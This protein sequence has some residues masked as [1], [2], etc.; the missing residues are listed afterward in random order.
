MVAVVVGGVVAVAVGC[1][2]GGG[3]V[4]VVGGGG[5]VAVGGAVVVTVAIV[6]AVVVTGGVGVGVGMQVM[7]PT[8]SQRFTSITQRVSTMNISTNPRSQK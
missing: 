5:G 7:L 6:V 1:R 8:E 4:V 3:V 2:V